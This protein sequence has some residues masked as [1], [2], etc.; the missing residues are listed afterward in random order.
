VLLPLWRDLIVFALKEAQACLFGGLMVAM[1]IGTHFFYPADARLARYDL[2]FLGALG[3]QA[4]LLLLRLETME[5][6]R[7]IFCFH[8]VGTAMELFKTSAG[9][10]IYPGEA[11]FRLGGVPLFSGFMYAAVGSYIARAWRIL[12]LRFR[13]YPP[14]WATVVLAVAIYVNFFS[15]HYTVDL[16]PGLFAASALVFG[17]TTVLFTAERRHRLPLILGLVLVTLFIWFAENIGTFTGTW[18][19]PSQQAAWQPVGLAKLGSW[20]LLMIISFVLVSLV[21]RPGGGA[22]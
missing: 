18:L 19:Y 10:W 4:A 13:R 1:L 20:Y 11:V 8:L 12:D 9:S 7:V 21:H 2:L 14:R 16:R 3:I 17:R 5:E 6:A 15:H 22:G